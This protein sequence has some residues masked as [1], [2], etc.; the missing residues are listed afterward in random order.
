MRKL[1]VVLAAIAGAVIAVY[2]AMAVATI[3][4]LTGRG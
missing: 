4:R 3:R 1:I 2:I